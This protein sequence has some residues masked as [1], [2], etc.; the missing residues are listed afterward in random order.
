MLGKAGWGW[1]LASFY[2][3][4]HP[5]ETGFFRV[6]GKRV[7]RPFC[8]TS[9]STHHGIRSDSVKAEQEQRLGILV[10]GLGTFPVTSRV[11]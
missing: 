8:A 2:L 11:H 10:P 3:E 1:T 7:P 4:G 6:R 5:G 9:S